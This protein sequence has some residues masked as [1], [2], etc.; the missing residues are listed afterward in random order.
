MFFG[1]MKKKNLGSVHISASSRGL[2]KSESFAEDSPVRVALAPQRLSHFERA[3]ASNG[4]GVRAK[5]VLRVGG[6]LPLGTD[7]FNFYVLLSTVPI[8]NSIV[9]T[10]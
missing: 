5:K 1:I 10:G 7:S 9:H 3:F 4:Q 6:T 8:S 2:Q